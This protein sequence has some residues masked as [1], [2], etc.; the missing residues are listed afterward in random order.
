MDAEALPAAVD[1][2]AAGVRWVGRVDTTSTAGQ[3][4]FAWSGSGFV[5]SF[6][7]TSLD[8]QLYDDGPF[9]FRAVVD[10]KLQPAFTSTAGQATYHLAAGLAAGDHTVELYRQTE[11]AQGTSRLVGLSAGGGALAAPPAGPGRFIEVIGDSISC[12]Y[13]MLGTK[14]DSDCFP[15]EDAYDTY[16][17]VTAR[18]LGADVSIVAASGRGVIRNYGGDTTDT[19]PMVYARAITNNAAP[20]WDFGVQPQAVI[21]NLGTNDISNNKGDPGTAFRDMYLQLVETVRGHYPDA[22]I[23][24]IIGPMLSGSDLTTIQGYLK[25]VVTARNAAGDARIE[26]FGAITAQGSDTYAC[27]YHPNVAENMTMAGQLTAELKS[28]LGW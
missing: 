26:F 6:S 12:G 18:A 5:A 25:D 11:G 1:V 28:K 27:Q 22:Y 14:T 19:M 13:G 9:I 21:I 20:A 17:A 7:G 2:V 23:F 10:G 15:T 3:P 16:G 24:C 8:A 4:Q